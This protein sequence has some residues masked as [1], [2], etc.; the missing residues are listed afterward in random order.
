M[1][2]ES[3][4]LYLDYHAVLCNGQS[5]PNSACDG[6]N[7]ITLPRSPTFRA[8]QLSEVLLLLVALV[9]GASYAVAKQAL[10][11]YSVLGFLAVRFGITFLLLLPILRGPGRRAWLPGFPLGGV[12]LG[13]F[14]CETYGVLLTTASNAAFLISLCVV[15]T[16]AVEWLLLGRRP[17]RSLLPAVVLSLSGAWLLNGGVEL[18]PGLGDGLIVVAALLRAVLVCLTRKYTLGRDV[19]PLALTAV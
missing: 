15:F 17:D 5:V 9:W 1:G 18:N 3:G 4:A 14:L 19:P 13:I 11:F 16:P 7:M 2:N 6:A 12:L 8:F 10:D